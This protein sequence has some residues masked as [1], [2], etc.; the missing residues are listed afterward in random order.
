M[1]DQHSSV[2]VVA[3]PTEIDIDSTIVAGPP[4]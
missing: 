2:L 1:S 4:G 3:V